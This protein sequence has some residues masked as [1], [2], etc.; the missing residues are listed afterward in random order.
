MNQ[1]C[2]ETSFAHQL[3]GQ[4]IEILLVV[5]SDLGCNIVKSLR[6]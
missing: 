2:N 4:R 1:Q 6:V 5:I 3:G